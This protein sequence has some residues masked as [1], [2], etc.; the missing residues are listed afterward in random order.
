[1]GAHLPLRLRGTQMR[2]ERIDWLI[3]G[4]L[5]L[6]TGSLYGATLLP[7]V[8]A[9]D[10]AEFQRAAPTLGL[11][12][13]TGYPLYLLLG[14]L[15]CH[16]PLGGT[17]AWRMNLLSA[18]AAAGANGA[19]FLC[20]RALG[21]LRTVALAAALAHATALTF[22]KQATIAEVYALA[23]LLEA[24]LLLSL[25][26]WR[27]GRAPL[28]LVGALCGLAL[29]HHRTAIF[30]LP[31]VALFVGLTR[32][33]RR[34][35]LLAAG[36]ALGA[37]GL[38]YLYVPLRMAPWLRSWEY[39]WDYITGRSLASAGFD[40]GRL[41]HD[42]ARRLA[43]VAQR[44]IGPQLTVAG[45]ALAALGAGRILRDR[46]SAALLLTTYVLTAL[47]SAAYYVYDAEVFLTHAH[48]VAALLLGEGAMAVIGLLTR[49]GSPRPWLRAALPQALG[50]LLL[51]LPL[52]LALR[53]APRVQ[54]ANRDV[55][56]FPVRA[57]MAQPLPPD[58]LMLVD[59]WYIYEELRYLQQVEGIR[60]DL[61]LLP[62]H[63]GSELL[64]YIEEALRSGRG[65][66][67][68][69][70][71]PG[72]PLAQRLEGLV[73]RVE[74]GPATLSVTT[75]TLVRWEH[76]VALS[77]Y[78]L[79]GQAYRAGEVVPITLAW[80][81]ERPLAGPL[82]VFI[83]LVGPDGTLWG[84][85]D[86]TPARLA[87]AVEAGR[88][89]LDLA[90]PILSPQAPPGSYRVELGWYDLSTLRRLALVDAAGR[91]LH[92]DFATLPVRLEVLP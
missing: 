39:V 77:G 40:P 89:Y 91:P 69:R 60:T 67:L 31:G 16:L 38:L 76:G 24:G 18:V 58:A 88:S 85:Q 41:Q 19:I 26:R 70:P 55:G 62:S 27:S 49:P 74:R 3:A 52:S 4:A 68:L 21:Q 54:A 51:A 10:I 59:W 37:A 2:E 87:G 20:G 17:P 13:P 63:D 11:A 53:N 65:V 72:L 7:D 81:T 32:R 78:A 28:A 1:M 33:P 47:F 42:G 14:W 48:V 64:S 71:Q 36:A 30:L 35:E 22:W 43:D 82:M 44:Y 80:Q 73:W 50:L 79:A 61:E 83:H 56:S 8:G 75:P 15:W 90:G 46:A 29:V 84:Q 34:G 25:W 57:I 9:G 6:A 5:A 92:T 86:Y 12:H 23:A 45:A 66:Y